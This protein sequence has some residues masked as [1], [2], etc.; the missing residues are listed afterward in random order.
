MI[1]FILSKS[2]MNLKNHIIKLYYKNYIHIQNLSMLDSVQVNLWFLQ[3]K[4]WWLSDKIS[5]LVI[6]VLRQNPNMTFFFTLYYDIL[7]PLL[8]WNQFNCLFLTPVILSRISSATYW[9]LIL[10]FNRSGFY[11]LLPIRSLMYSKILN[12]NIWWVPSSN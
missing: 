3:L 4:I 1:L 5:T 11:T 7:F 9:D 8:E 6:L 10:F 2:N 12:K